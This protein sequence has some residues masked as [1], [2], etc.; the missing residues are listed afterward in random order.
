MVLEPR[1]FEKIIKYIVYLLSLLI[2]ITL[3]AVIYGMYI[4]I[5]PK[6]SKNY[7]INEVISLSLNQDH[8]IINMQVINDKRILI[9]ISDGNE[10]QGIIFDIDSQ[11]IIQRIKK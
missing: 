5:S 3:I 11:T 2:I 7:N 4:N 9:T 6:A 8:E 10:I 1:M